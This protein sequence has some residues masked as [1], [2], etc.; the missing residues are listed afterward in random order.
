MQSCELTRTLKAGPFSIK[1]WI[2]EDIDSLDDTWRADELMALAQHVAVRINHNRDDDED[3][4]AMEVALKIA[5]LLSGIAK[6]E[7]TDSLGHGCEVTP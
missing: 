4:D 1:L 7:V 5:S 6:V 3:E 2:A